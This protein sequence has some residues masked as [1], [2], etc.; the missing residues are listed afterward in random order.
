MLGGSGSGSTN[1]GDLKFVRV[2]FPKYLSRKPYYRTAA[3]EVGGKTFPLETGQDL[4]EIAMKTLEDRMIRELSKSLLRLAV[5][6]AAE[7]A[8]RSKNENLGA[9]FSIAQ[10]L[11]EKADTRNWRF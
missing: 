11:S 8:V 9:L 4:N 7:Q 2:V 1:L 10:A 5:K 3:L 6:Q